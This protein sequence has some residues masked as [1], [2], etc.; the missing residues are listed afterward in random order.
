MIEN[1]VFNA[2]IAVLS[3]AFLSVI[4]EPDISL[5]FKYFAKRYTN[6]TLNL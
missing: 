4:P 1:A 2:A 6:D 3:A 5:C